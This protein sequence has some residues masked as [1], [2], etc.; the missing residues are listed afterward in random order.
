MQVS[1]AGYRYINSAGQVLKGTIYGEVIA[2]QVEGN[3]ATGYGF[4]RPYLLVTGKD[5][6]VGLSLK[7]YR[8]QGKKG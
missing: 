2:V 3:L 6:F 5:S 8:A 4:Y 1:T 7:V